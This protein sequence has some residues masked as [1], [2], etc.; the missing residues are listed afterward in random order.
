VETKAGSSELWHILTTYKYTEKAH[1]TWKEFGLESS[2][3]L[4]CFVFS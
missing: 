1:E 3:S 4:N 2:D